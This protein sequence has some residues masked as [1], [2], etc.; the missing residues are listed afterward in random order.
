M[1]GEEDDEVAAAADEASAANNI[2]KYLFRRMVNSYIFIF[3]GIV[4][5]AIKKN[6]HYLGN[7]KLLL[8]HNNYSIR[9]N[10]H[11]HKCIFINSIYYSS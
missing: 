9:C 8:L 3:R 1:E 4:L 5:T 6:C 2:H 7:S 10:L 11:I